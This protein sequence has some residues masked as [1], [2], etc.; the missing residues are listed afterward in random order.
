MARYI[1]ATDD[2]ATNVRYP[3]VGHGFL[4]GLVEPDSAEA[5]S[6]DDAW[7]RTV[8]FLRRHVTPG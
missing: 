6:A 3:D 1:A 8:D 5:D 2:V 7:Q 4:R